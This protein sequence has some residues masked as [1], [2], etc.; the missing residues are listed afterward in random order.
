MNGRPKKQKHGGARRVNSM[1]AACEV[2]V[3]KWRSSISECRFRTLD[4]LKHWLQPCNYFNDVGQGPPFLNAV[5]TW[6]FGA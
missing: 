5:I 1:L 6:P 2:D 4:Q 3:G